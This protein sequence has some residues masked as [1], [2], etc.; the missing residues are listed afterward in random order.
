[1][2]TLFAL[3][4]DTTNAIDNEALI[5]D[6]KNELPGIE[7]YEIAKKELVFPKVTV[8][9]LLNRGWRVRFQIRSED[10]MTLSLEALQKI[11]GKKTQLPPDFLSYNKEIAI[12]FGDD[13][14]KL[15]T[16]DIIF[17][18]EFIRENYPGVVI[19]DQYNEDVW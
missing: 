4:K 3:V 15:Y 14:D 19:Y 11:L 9:Q 18:G 5:H 8:V 10:S 6:L 16:N 17:I 13:P 1:M 7:Q 12:G 2:F